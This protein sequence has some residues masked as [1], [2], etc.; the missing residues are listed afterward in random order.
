[1]H[2]RVTFALAIAPLLAGCAAQ[3]AM[4]PAPVGQPEISSRVKPVLT[5]DGLRFRDLDADGALSPF[6]DWRLAEERRASDLLA[7]MT[8][9]EKAG[10]LLH[11]TMPG[12]VNQLGR[13][14]SYDKDELTRMVTGSHITSLITRLGT[15]PAEVATENNAAQEIAEGA[16][17][18]IPLTISS[19][20]RN[21]F[22]YVLGA[23]ESA[24][25]TTQWP[26][27]LGF[28][29]L[30]DGERMH[31]FGD[32]ARAE[33]RAVGIHMA[34]SPQLDLFTEPRWPRGAA[35][36][37]SDAE[38]ASRLGADYV[39][40]MQGSREGLTR[41][42]V[43]TVAKHWVGYGA[44]PE[45][46]DGH[47][48]YGR[49]T[50]P[51]AAFDDHVDAFRGALDVNVAGIMPAYPILLD[52]MVDG[53]PAAPD[54]PGYSEQLLQGLLREK[55][56]Y[57]GFIL[58]DWAITRDCNERCIAP[59]EDAP[60]RPQDIATSWGVEDLSVAERYAKGMRAGIDQFGGTDDVAP[61]LEAIRAG[62]LP[63]ERV[64][65]AVMRVMLPK[66][67]LGLFENPYVDPAAATALVG[68]PEAAAIARQTQREA[69]VM[70]RNEGAVL[71]LR[72]G[73]KVW[74]SGMSADAARDAGLIPVDDIAA[75]DIAIVRGETASEML[76]PHH[77]FGM[78]QKEGRLDFREGDE[79]FDALGKAKAAGLPTVL[80]IFLDR[81]AV[82]TGTLARADAILGNFG[83]D[84]AAVLD[85]L[86]GRSV[87]RG[88]LPVELPRSM[89]AVAAQH[90]G[91]PDDSTD[92]LFEKGF[93]L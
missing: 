29:A 82:L 79:P 35:T 78:R 67:W 59:T 64:D 68:A 18:A 33:Y 27:L 16:R 31:R 7:R 71:P 87:A 65:D 88:R 57:D 9:E 84:D 23:S 10:T 37:G 66:F 54:S 14:S 86:M 26:E 20:P 39:A 15:P 41:D 56:G 52:T 83:A 46:Y 70:L 11:A 55:L 92:P 8:V 4:A 30:D 2:N 61:L 44:Q 24:M 42:G 40:G 80:A 62:T 19:D 43:I 50:R 93:G 69:Q 45:G 5:V 49:F 60:Q 32:V 1:M 75:A 90:P 28:A 47:N 51:G 12:E 53:E 91:L 13:G 48:Y 3:Q 74:L 85:V 73:A 6:E 72:E 22:Q 77:F 76:H 89:D 38:I 36:F 81:P 17:I 21:H 25:G 34:L 63:M 58:S